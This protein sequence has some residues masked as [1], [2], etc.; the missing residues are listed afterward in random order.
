MTATRRW[1]F[2]VGVAGLVIAI[3]QFTKQLVLRNLALYESV[4]PV[5]ALAPFFQITRSYNTGSAF[6]F[7]AGLSFSGTLF[8]VV[9][10]VI[11]AVLVYSYARLGP[12]QQ[13][14]QWA[15]ALV[16]GGAL[17]NVLDRML[18]DGRVIDFIHY[19]IPNVISNLSNVADHAIVIGVALMVLASW[20]TEQAEQQARPQH[21]ETQEGASPPA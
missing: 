9:A 19:Q 17:G 6:G 13:L 1:V 18:H 11:T 14:A 10:L 15:T 7:L 21:E 8:L 5:P 4:Q 20:G 16:I 3:D 2:L 12:E